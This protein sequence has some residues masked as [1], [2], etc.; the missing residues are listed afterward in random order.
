M[1]HAKNIGRFWAEAIKRA[2]DMIDLLDATATF[3]SGATKTDG[4]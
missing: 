2:I 1:I 4:W 3:T